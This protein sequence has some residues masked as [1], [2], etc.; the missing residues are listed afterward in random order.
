MDVYAEMLEHSGE[1]AEQPGI[2]SPDATIAVLTYVTFFILLAILYKFAWKPI[3][4]ILDAREETIRRS[5]EDAQ[6]AREDLEK[7]QEKSRQLILDADNKALEIVEQARKGAIEAANAV[8]RKAKEEVQIMINNAHQEI[9]A[10]KEKAQMSLRQESADWAV[11]LA[12]AIIK[13]NLDETRHQK[14]VDR[15]IEEF[16]PKQP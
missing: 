16:T 11:R 10:L 5:L 13:E 15:F 12:Q 14:L 6:K 4:A 9:N 7:I 2:L 3:L 1:A 8:E